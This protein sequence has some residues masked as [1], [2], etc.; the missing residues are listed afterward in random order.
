MRI[1]LRQ[2]VNSIY[3]LRLCVLLCTLALSACGA[4]SALRPDNAKPVPQERIYLKLDQSSE[5]SARVVIVRDFTE[6]YRSTYHQI[7]LD[8]KRIATLANGEKLEIFLKPG[9]YVFGALPTMSADRSEPYSAGFAVYNLDQVLAP[10][11]TYFYRVLID[12]NAITRMQRYLPD[13][14]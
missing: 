13:A 10:R 6:L 3:Y 2:F 7:F 12:V 11:K 14:L 8:G 1:Q 5:D 4:T 9:D